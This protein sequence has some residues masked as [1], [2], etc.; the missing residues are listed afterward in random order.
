M[1]RIEMLSAIAGYQ[2]I[3]VA[4]E[5]GVYRGYYSELIYNSMKPGK[6]YLVD[7][8][9]KLDDYTDLP[10]NDG[11]WEGIYQEAKARLSYPNVHIIRD[12]SRN[13]VKQFADRSV[14]FV[15]IDGN[16]EYSHV[17]EDLELWRPK[18]AV[19][20][21]LCGHDYTLYGVY[22]AVQEFARKYRH[23][24]LQTEELRNNSFVFS[25]I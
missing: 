25:S 13:A 9:R 22:T 10:G 23:I 21:F 2:K 1:D 15:Y 19:G 3:N 14:D 8:W 11:D 18:I 6:L 5:I 20:G 24:F 17:L 12:I 16:H 7:P 4:V